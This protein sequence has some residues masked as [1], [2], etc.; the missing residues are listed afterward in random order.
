[1]ETAKN[2]H[3]EADKEILFSKAIKAG[4]RIYYLDVKMNRRQEMYVSITESKKTVTGGADM[5]Q[6]NY[7]KHKV[8]IYKED[9]QKFVDG[10]QEILGYIQKEQGEAEP[11][12]EQDEE[13]KIDMEF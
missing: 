3:N 5:P 9:F 10:F 7:E 11:R 1:M 13:I 2:N 6:V 4:Q 12:P 8:F